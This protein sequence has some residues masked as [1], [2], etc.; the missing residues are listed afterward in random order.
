MVR[1]FQLLPVFALTPP[2]AS[3]P[4]R[5]ALFSALVS[6]ASSSFIFLWENCA[7]W[8]NHRFPLA[9]LDVAEGRYLRRTIVNRT[10]GTHKNLYVHLFLVTIFGPIYYDPPIPR[11]RS[12]HL[13]LVR[14]IKTLLGPQ[15][16][17]GDKPGKFEVVCPQNRTA[18]LRG[19]IAHVA[20]W[21][22]HIVHDTQ[23]LRVA[24]GS[25]RDSRS[26]GRMK[27]N[28]RPKQLG[29]KQATYKCQEL[30]APS[31]QITRTPHACRT[32]VH[33]PGM[34]SYVGYLFFSFRYVG[35]KKSTARHSSQQ[36]PPNT[37]QFS[38]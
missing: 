6:V 35:R 27:R 3:F 10:C 4:W 24:G 7:P 37:M 14:S 2:P 25:A 21:D 31:R 12:L 38:K 1:L 5:P 18:V 8:I 32:Y 16:R 36:H 34:Y 20:G 33:T 17:F 19:L 28:R 23:E 13:Y 22:L 11:D 26:R 30:H 9:D 29:C 15:S